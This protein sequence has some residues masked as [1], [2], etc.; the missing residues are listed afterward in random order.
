VVTVRSLHPG[1][2]GCARRGDRSGDGMLHPACERNAM[3]DLTSDGVC[4]VCGRLCRAP[5]RV[6][7]AIVSSV[8][9]VTGQLL[10]P[11]RPTMPASAD[12]PSYRQTLS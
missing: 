2:A 9:W 6:R 4:L 1:G 12:A 8:V 3:H 5:V 7:Q 10:R 11:V